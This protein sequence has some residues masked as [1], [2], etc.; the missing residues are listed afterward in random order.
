M[1]SSLTEPRKSGC[2][3]LLS[4]ASSP[5]SDAALCVGRLCLNFLHI[6]ECAEI[7]NCLMKS[8]HYKCDSENRDALLDAAAKGNL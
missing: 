7:L 8:L 3:S 1:I 6:P 5:P 2:C 4:P